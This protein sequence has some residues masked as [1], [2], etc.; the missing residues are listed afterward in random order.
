ML[1]L[2]A[3]VGFLLLLGVVVAVLL[4]FTY[5]CGKCR[6]LWA[7]RRVEEGRRHH[8]VGWGFGELIEYVYCCKH[9]GHTERQV[10]GPGDGGP[11]GGE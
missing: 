5:R 1:D 4:G 9:C 7:I 10:H 6:R 2:Y 8:Q 11:D 3:A